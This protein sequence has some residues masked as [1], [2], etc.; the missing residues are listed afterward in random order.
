MK[1]YVEIK[2]CSVVLPEFLLLSG[3]LN[4]TYRVNTCN[5]VKKRSPEDKYNFIVMSTPTNYPEIKY[6][7]FVK[8]M[9]FALIHSSTFF[10]ALS[11]VILI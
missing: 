11:R 5:F 8:L 4:K 1:I 6:H 2:V 7:L 9:Y 3:H 10:F